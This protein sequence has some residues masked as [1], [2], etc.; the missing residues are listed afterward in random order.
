[1]HLC[2]EPIESQDNHVN[3]NISCMH[4][5]SDSRQQHNYTGQ[6][7]Q[8]E[9]LLA[10]MDTPKEIHLTCNIITMKPIYASLPHIYCI[11]V[12]TDMLYM[13][14]RKK[15]NFSGLTSTAGNIS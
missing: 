11:L 3:H 2:W 10:L 6:K 13:K 8:T 5:A 4:S 12:S 15:N 9:V 1:M 14:C 7:T